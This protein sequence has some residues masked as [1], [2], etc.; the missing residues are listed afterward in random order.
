MKKLL[1]VSQMKVFAVKEEKRKPKEK[2]N[3]ENPQK[4]NC[5]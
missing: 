3:Q 4:E 2:E 1:A 5:S